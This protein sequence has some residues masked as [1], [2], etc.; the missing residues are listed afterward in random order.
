MESVVSNSL[1]QVYNNK[2]D[3]KELNNET[4]NQLEATP[5]DVWG[6]F[7]VMNA[8]FRAKISPIDAIGIPLMISGRV[9]GLDTKKGL[10]F[11]VVDIWHTSPEAVYDYQEADPTKIYPY[12]EE[13]NTHGRSTNYDYRA[14][15]VTDEGGRYEFETVKPVPYFDTDD[16]TWRCPHIH[17]YVQSHG[18]KPLVTQLYFHGEEKNDIGKK[19]FA[20]A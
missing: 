13:L 9:F 8:P 2:S 4:T 6:P 19:T 11:A 15:L 3:D 12:R 17:Y 5:K 18:Y 16:S 14:R 7:Y 20:F 1:A 10:P